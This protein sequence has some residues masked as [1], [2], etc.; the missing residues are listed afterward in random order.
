[1]PAEQQNKQAA[2]S[3]PQTG[4]DFFVKS[5]AIVLPSGG[6][7]IRSIDEKLNVNAVS[8]T[9]EL[10]IP[11][12]ITPARG[13]E[14]ALSLAYNS[15]A[16][17][18]AFGLGWNVSLPSISRKTEKQLPQYTDDD[19]YLLAGAE[20]LVP[21]LRKQGDKWTPV[22]F[23]EG[24]YEVARYC[25]RIESQYQK[26]E[27]WKKN[28]GDIFWKI[29]SGNN[30]ASFYGK[31]PR[32]KIAD[33]AD[34][35]KIFKWLIN[36]SYDDKGN[37]I[38]Y[39]YKPEDTLNVQPHIFEQKHVSGATHIANTYIKQVRYGN[40]K[41]FDASSNIA[42]QY[43]F[44]I[45][46]DYGENNSTWPARADAF[47]DFRAGFEIRTYR[48]CKSISLFHHFRQE[49]GVDDYLVKS[50][51][52]SYKETNSFSY[53]D[54]VTSR[55]YILQNDGTYSSKHF[56]PVSFT[57][58]EAKINTAILPLDPEHTWQLPAFT[59]ASCRWIDL[60]SEGVPGILAEQGNAWYYK[61]NLGNGKFSAPQQIV[62]TP[63]FRGLST[64][65]LQLQ[66]IASDGS[67]QLVS[68][69]D[70]YKGF[71]ELSAN[72]EWLPFR[73]FETMP[74][75]KLS[76]PNI[77]FVDLD[78]DGVADIL[79]C[80]DNVF[81][82]HRSKGREGYEAANAVYHHWNED[83][84]PR[85]VFAD[86]SQAIFLADI[87]GDGLS[88]ILRVRNNEIVYWP[89]LGYGRFGDKI[90]MGNAPT[91]DHPELFDAKNVM[92][93]DID[94][95]GIPDLIYLSANSI[96]IWMN[97]SGNQW[98]MEPLVIDLPAINKNT[99]VSVLDVT[100]NGTASIVWASALPATIAPA[101]QYINLLQGKK[102]HLM[103]AVSNSMGK[104]TSFE[105]TSST[106]FYLKDKAVGKPWITKLPF[107]VHC[108]SRVVVKD[109]PAGTTFTSSYTY[110]HGYYDK[111][112]REFRGFGRVEQT[113][114]ETYDHFVMNG[115]ALPAGLNQL[116]VLTKTWFH[117]GAFIP[118]A[119]MLE[120]FSSEYYTNEDF[121]EHTLPAAQLL[122][123]LTIAE[124]RE[125][126]RACKNMILRREIF[127][128][129]KNGEPFAHPYTTAFHN[130]TLR[131]LRPRQ[132][133]KH[134][135]FN[136]MESEAITYS[137]EQQPFNPRI[138]H[139]VNLQTNEFGQVLRSVSI[140]YGRKNIPQNLPPLLKE[141]QERT[142]IVFTQ[143]DYSPL[144]NGFDY[145]L[146]VL[147]QSMTW[148]VT[149]IVAATDFFSFDELYSQLVTN[150]PAEIAYHSEPGA[151][152][153]RR[154][155]EHSKTLFYDASLSAS[156]LPGNVVCPVIPFESFKLAFPAAT[157]TPLTKHL[158]GTRLSNKM[159]E[160]A[161]YQLHADGNWW[162]PSGKQL[163]DN[164][165]KSHFYQ[166]F[167]M[168]DAFGNRFT[169][170]YTQDLFVSAV[171]DPLNNI[172]TIEQT[173]FR[174]LQPRLLKDENNNTSE[175]LYDELGM[176]V[177]KSIYGN[178][179]GDKPLSAYVRK[180]AQ[181]I[182][183]IIAAP[184]L[185]LQ[186]CTEFYYYDI[187]AIPVQFA[188]V[189]R[190]KHAAALSPG[191]E[192]PVQC[193]VGYTSGGGY[194]LQ[195]KKQCEPGDDNAARWLGTGRTVLN[196]KG[197]A[198]KQYEPFFSKHHRY[199]TEKEVIENGV[200]ALIFYD[201]LGRV[202]KKI[203]PDKTGV[204]TLFDAWQQQSWDASDTVL[205]TDI[206]WL[207]RADVSAT[208]K[209]ATAIHAATPAVDFVD[210]SG[211]IVYT[212][213]HNKWQNSS[214]II[215]EEKYHNRTVFDIE[216][217]QRQVIDARSNVVMQ[218]HYNMLGMIC[219]Q[220]SMDA[221]ERW[222]LT[223]VTGKPCRLWDSRQQ[224]QATEYDALRRPLRK[225]L[226][227]PPT[228]VELIT[229]VFE[230]GEGQNNDQQLNLRGRLY[231][232]FD[233]SGCITSVQYDLK[234][235]A[236]AVKKRLFIEQKS[237]VDCTVAA[238]EP[239]E[240]TQLTTY[241][242]L[243]RIVEMHS[244][245]TANLPA[246]IYKPV[247]NKRGL[248]QSELLY[249]RGNVQPGDNS[250]VKRIEYNSRGQK[251]KII[252]GN[253]SVT[254]Y[255]YDKDTFRLLSLKTTAK[256][257]DGSINT[258]Q[259][260]RYDYDASGNVISIVDNAQQT[261]YFRNQVVPPSCAYTY[262]ALY[263]LIAAAGREHIG[264]NKITDAYDADRIGLT[265]PHDGA[266]MSN[267]R[268]EYEYDEA[269]NILKIRH[270][271]LA[272]AA[273]WVRQY[274]YHNSSNRLLSTEDE[275]K[276]SVPFYSDTALLTNKYAY[277]EHGSMQMPHLQEMQWDFAEQLSYLKNGTLE[278]W[279]RY[280][281]NKQRTRKTIE[282]GN[283]KE[284]R[285]Y[286]GETEI[287]R[288]WDN[289]V[290]K[291]ENETLH[292]TDAGG[293][294]LLAEH[295]TLS[296]T[297]IAGAILFR[298]Q[299]PNH[300][301]SASLE[302]N[303][304]NEVVSY[305]EF[306]PYGSTAYQAINKNIVALT[307]RYRYT[308]MER[309]EESGLNY[310]TARYYAPWLG[311]WCS[312]D[313]EMTDAGLN[314]FEYAFNNPINHTDK[315]GNSPHKDLKRIEKPKDDDSS[316]SL[317]IMR[318]AVF[319]TSETDKK[320]ISYLKH[321]LQVSYAMQG[322]S[323][324]D[325]TVRFFKDLTAK[326]SDD[327]TYKRD[328][329]QSFLG[330]TFLRMYLMNRVDESAVESARKEMAVSPE[331]KGLSEGLHAKIEKAVKSGTTS[332][333]GIEKT[334]KQY[335]AA[336]GKGFAFRAELNAVIGGVTGMEVT[337]VQVL[338]QQNTK[339]GVLAYQVNVKFNDTY[340]FEN[341]R[342]G[343]YDKYRKHLA[344]LLKDKKF[345]EFEESYVREAFDMEGRKTS[346]DK[347]GVFASYMYALEKAGYTEGGVDW[348]VTLPITG[349]VTFDKPPGRSNKIS[350]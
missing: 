302:L 159:L 156:L 184:L 195:M 71:S 172:T 233:Q 73:M 291:E 52:L 305:E 170:Q 218:Y 38:E 209:S 261:I 53:L 225:K 278:A 288:R 82:W 173:D 27:R 79:I 178:G 35:K 43:F 301:G 125:A 347:A 293:R 328:K 299:Y 148:E 7:A 32:A 313:P 316:Q 332:Q 177:A 24:D 260:L 253:N 161:G 26:I 142:E 181:N 226:I 284:E 264:Q 180:T 274:Q 146:P 87:N 46:F 189:T 138:L 223:D 136:V 191:E 25:P 93:Q 105:Y 199:E 227:L 131:V 339:K 75:V 51:D 229:E 47:S 318:Q 296:E 342:T 247:Y 10:N 128:C 306:H 268:E 135:V 230:Y 204:K 281:A 238:F 348:S 340:D 349:T 341:K 267:Y 54:T 275:E 81:L 126:H 101:M 164:N 203:L 262:D 29:V 107:P 217:N 99:Q 176:V 331:F 197:N 80:N 20:D 36:F 208:A 74:N 314:V 244:W 144:I 186:E 235:N 312:A 151:G 95:S 243:D 206:E 210:S 90:T 115:S 76:D 65:M 60:Y 34:A 40:K 85:T 231:K 258:F 325:S 153:S 346:L 50:L 48:R 14:P 285:I 17:N 118:H 256:V 272:T 174:L 23:N 22:I 165:A 330:G 222:L 350:K 308:G 154:L 201:P 214:G 200:T 8:G 326:A 70:Q 337:G 338:S 246:S 145:H 42:P 343:E 292:I 317:Q 294:M 205:D 121:N 149:G 117:T 234:G 193:S 92:L 269:G 158:F 248:M 59:D 45:Q 78:G 1:M 15:G 287:F 147:Y 320:Q 240:Y 213:L 194:M 334:A 263:R 124:L 190:E 77:H 198:V 133:N 37:C 219:Y 163:F 86:S 94:G 130:C 242:A 266:Q 96:K 102:P 162:M 185:F 6:G 270:H 5:P 13:F 297:L 57:Y 322:K 49:L 168:Q 132:D 307:K 103:V 224:Q 303:E 232:H 257:A 280:D 127:A 237:I 111:A 68:L 69:S 41:P 109:V 220:Q 319:G 157:G 202:I 215:K 98:Q 44:S 122:P 39:I 62:E 2:G 33:P 152:A 169:M 123:E 192:T 58:Q 66:D 16:G 28:D 216:G 72:E 64:G 311:R 83:E 129:N 345:Q 3:T 290:L 241:D 4:N 239:Q 140:A 89:N 188:N 84:G 251:T 166:P 333:A 11:V 283:V 327:K 106:Q 114:S 271:I 289:N 55:G 277:N 196:N 112:E 329:V 119:T 56:P 104:I 324:L 300:L 286:L 250:L 91:P 273:G 321:A 228:D 134:A 175:V 255:T 150:R 211:R 31:D 63:S 298:Y 61:S 97:E 137:Y 309:D 113:D 18:S 276:P 245:H 212:I 19:V 187:T 315:N 139:S 179:M 323:A 254:T 182:D 259:D 310:H 120:Q 143:N 100:G 336:K 221:G 21:Y 167:A 335:I 67:R 279:Y 183:E 249:I 252:Y 141:A 12:P 265:H 116:P 30:I 304:N 344:Q 155:I 110:H 160:D 108:L 207:G 295:I 236:T 282:K 88:D 9:A 171:K